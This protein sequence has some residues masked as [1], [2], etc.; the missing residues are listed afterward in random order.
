MI[1]GR[2]GSSLCV[3]PAGTTFNEIGD[4][5]RVGDGLWSCL[6]AKRPERLL[7]YDLWED[8]LLQR[9]VNA[10]RPDLVEKYTALLEEQV[11]ANAAMR[12]LVGAGG[13]RVSLTPEQLQTLRA[14]GYI[15]E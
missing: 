11:E 14:L 5:V 4:A 15:Q 10:Q 13:E 1:D 9:P 12:E 6:D 8:P 7:V 2:W 3:R